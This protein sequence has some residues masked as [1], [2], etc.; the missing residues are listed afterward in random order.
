[1]GDEMPCYKKRANPFG[2]AWNAL[3][4]AGPFEIL[5]AAAMK[6]SD[7]FTSLVSTLVIVV[8]MLLSFG[9]LA[10]SMK[11]LPL[12]TA[13]TIRT[14]IGSFGA[15]TLGILYLGEALPIAR[16]AATVLNVTGLVLIKNSVP[17]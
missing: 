8:I 6:Q 5:W 1:M 15:F 12:G 7:G 3:S 14:G 4:L 17:A 9:L 10:W 16:I 13:Y 11:V 2:I